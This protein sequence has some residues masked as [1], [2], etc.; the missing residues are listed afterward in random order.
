[1]WAYNGQ[2]ESATGCWEAAVCSGNGA[3]WMF[4]GRAIQWFCDSF[5]ASAANGLD[6]PY[7][8]ERADE[9]HFES[10][11]PGCVYDEDCPDTTICTFFLWDGTQDGKSYGNGSACYYHDVGVCPAENHFASV[12]ANY[13]GDDGTGFSSYTQFA[14]TP[15]MEV[16]EGA[17]Y[18][19]SATFAAIAALMIAMN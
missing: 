5:S 6:I 15:P 3:Y 9:P 16:A 2:S 11:A 17:S 1:M 8:L 12:N 10:F 19:G 4:D 18:I 13:W 14:C 7:G